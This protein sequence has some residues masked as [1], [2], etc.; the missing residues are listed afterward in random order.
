MS[1][2]V[3]SRC[4]IPDFGHVHQTTTEGTRTD[5]QRLEP[6]LGRSYDNKELF[7]LFRV[8]NYESLL[9]KLA[10]IGV[11]PYCDDLNKRVCRV[12]PVAG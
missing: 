2:L 8:S 11:R 1:T 7:P 3:D 9:V 6:S 10:E 12:A 4:R 5:R